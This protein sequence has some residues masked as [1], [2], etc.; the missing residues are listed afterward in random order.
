MSIK[1]E[2]EAKKKI[3]LPLSTELELKGSASVELRRKKR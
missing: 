3:D 2:L 1:D